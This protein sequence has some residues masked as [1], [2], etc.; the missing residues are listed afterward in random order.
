MSISPIVQRPRRTTALADGLVW[1][2]KARSR[3]VELEGVRCLLH[4][5]VY[6]EYTLAGSVSIPIND[7]SCCGSNRRSHAHFKFAHASCRLEFP[8]MRV[9]SPLIW[10]TNV[11]LFAQR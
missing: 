11:E 7:I 10:N 9:T 4:K 6:V 3:S 8:R 5:R 1:C 2:W